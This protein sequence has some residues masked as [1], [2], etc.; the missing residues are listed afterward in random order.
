MK[1]I[2]FLVSMFSLIISPS[3][4]YSLNVTSTKS[5]A[6]LL[7]EEQ[8][9]FLIKPDGVQRGLIGKIIQRLEEKGLKLIA[10]KIVRVSDQI[11]QI[12]QID[13]K[14][15]FTLQPS[16]ELVEKHYDHLRD[17]PFFE[18][19]V[20]Y[21]TSSPLMATVWEGFKAISH[22]RQMLGHSIDPEVGTIRFDYSLL[23]SR[24]I[25]HGSHD[26]KSANAE[27]ALWFSPNE[28]VPWTQSNLPFIHGYDFD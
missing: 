2:V 17:K 12:L 22:I 20:A 10:A 21:M 6:T 25:A 4:Q 24:N 23:K 15:S 28:L 18:P 11:R 8:S 1:S 16:R 3:I 9:L 27:I 7:M 26:L 19:M 5:S 13:T 14:T